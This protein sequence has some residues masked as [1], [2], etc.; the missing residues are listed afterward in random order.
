[1]RL[2]IVSDIH[3][4]WQAWRAVLRDMQAQDV[5]GVLCL[6]DIVGYGPRP[7]EVLEDIL[8]RCENFVLG[9]HDA[10]I[11][12]RLDPEIFSDDARE[13]I[14]W[15]RGRLDASATGFF[16]QLPL[17]MVDDDILCV[18]AEAEDPERYAYIFEPA[19]ALPT[20]LSCDSR[21]ILFGHTHIP[22][23]FAYDEETGSVTSGRPARTRLL[24]NYRYLVNVGSVG[25]PRDG[26]EQASYCILDRDAR[27]ID[28]RRVPF[29]YAAYRRELAAT[30]LANVP[31]FLQV[32]DRKVGA[33]SRLSDMDT[34]RLKRSPRAMASR[35]SAVQI[36]VDPGLLQEARKRRMATPE[37]QPL[38]RRAKVIL[39]ASG[40]AAA[41]LVGVGLG[42]WSGRAP[43]DRNVPSRS[44]PRR[45][46]TIEPDLEEPGTAAANAAGKGPKP[47]VPD[48]SPRAAG[49]TAGTDE[50][51]PQ[52]VAGAPAMPEPR[53]EP[54]PPPAP[55]PAPVG[56]AQPIPEPALTQGPPAGPPGLLAY[57]GFEYPEGELAG[58]TGG[59]G[60][61]GG[62]S[63]VD[64]AG[65]RVVRGSL[66]S[67]DPA[68]STATGNR[69]HQPS[70]SR[71]G[72]RLDTSPGGAF[73]RA[74]YL[75]GR[76]MIGAY[77]KTLYV[78]F[79]QQPTREDRFWEFE[80]HRGDLGDRGRISGIGNDCGGKDVHL[81][82]PHNPVIAAA[83]TGVSFYVVRIDYKPGKDDVLV[84]RNPPRETEPAPEEAAVNVPGFHDMNFNGISF[85]AFGQGP[86]VEHDEIRIGTSYV[87][88]ATPANYIPPGVVAMMLQREFSGAV[89]ALEKQNPQHE[90]LDKLRDLALKLHDV[91][92]TIMDS[93]KEDIGKQVTIQF[94][95]GTKRTLRI[96]SVRN[97]QITCTLEAGYQHVTKDL[98]L[99]DLHLNER[100]HRLG[101]A[102]SPAAWVYHGLMAAESGR[103]DLAKESF[104]KLGEGMG[105]ALAGGIDETERTMARAGLAAILT[106]GGVK[107]DPEHLEEAVEVLLRE[108]PPSASKRR[109]LAFVKRY[110]TD[111]EKR[112][113][114]PAKFAEMLTRIEGTL[115]PRSGYAG[116]PTP[117]SHWPMDELSGST[118]RDKVGTRNGTMHGDAKR[119]PGRSR[120]CLELGG[121][122]HVEVS[123]VR[124]L[125][126]KEAMTWTAWIKTDSPGTI[127]ACTARGEK[128]SR[129]GRCFLVEGK[130]LAL[131][132]GWVAKVTGDT[133]M[134]DGNWHHVGVTLANGTAVKFY[135]DGKPAG[136]ANLP[137]AASSL[138]EQSVFR[139][140]LTN[141]DA[142]P[143]FT[144]LIDDVMCYDRAFTPEQVKK[145]YDRLR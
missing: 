134:A 105:E 5:E 10:V 37:K 91:D 28:F 7:A 63:R 107:A 140:G 122:G 103:P 89:S 139:I 61:S 131:D 81:R 136:E 84:F 125:V 82:G 42:W 47:P 85:G 143:R 118:V 49:Q 35:A 114:L 98:R 33:E 60:W 20:F 72:R 57:D 133:E 1:M 77:D 71:I 73:D 88:V 78:S 30:G 142:K 36:H 24:A 115:A 128:W 32:I 59:A 48:S 56:P 93:F 123:A 2:A 70:N 8:S 45:D 9:N 52:G 102:D 26:R 135:V 53:Q 94:A 12:D 67:E 40:V 65:G 101:G 80:F 119:R 117:V 111:L 90:E 50:T 108:P 74:G 104:A 145:L 3:A 6:G 120:G 16:G 126:P 46:L 87:A 11:P 66:S 99:Q 137:R 129:G 17:A 97:R 23:V 25:D 124:G 109:L 112:Q 144:G 55:K 95:G 39:G 127:A 106:K 51:A 43:A 22:G 141:G 83:D 58:Q 69:A 62:W 44:V 38:S 132:V 29:D 138:P 64:G 121:E 21:L 100:L 31:Y 110:R 113:A 14:E 79:L 18:H 13:A 27:Y 19:E 34:Q 54:P 15:T 92:A 116:L 68:A 130:K 75:N 4:N 41:L 86:T 76:G 96:E